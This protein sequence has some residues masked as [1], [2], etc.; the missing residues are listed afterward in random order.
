M[1]K[2]VM[3]KIK[4]CSKSDLLW[5][6]ERLCCFDSNVY[7]VNI[8]LRELNHMKEMQR[9]DEADEYAKLADEKRKE[10]IELITPYAGKPISDIPDDV[11][12]KSAKLMREARTAEMKYCQ[13]IGIKEG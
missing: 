6:V 8:A 2:R 7:H 10:H 1:Y 12:K 3:A 13:L 9:I 5:I 4:K 11:L